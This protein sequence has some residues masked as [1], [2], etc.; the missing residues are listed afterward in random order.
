[1]DKPSRIEI[2]RRKEK[3]G[4]ARESVENRHAFIALTL[5]V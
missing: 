1:M 2:G 4:S 5:G 3:L